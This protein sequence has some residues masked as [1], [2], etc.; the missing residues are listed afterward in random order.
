MDSP[1]TT[2][3]LR[4]LL[5]WHL[6]AGV[7]ETIGEAPVDRYAVHS[8]QMAARKQAVVAPGPAPDKRAAPAIG[9][10]AA[11]HDAVALAAGASSVAELKAAVER[12]EGCGLKETATN[13]CF[14]DGNPEARL[15]LIGEG[16]GAEEDRQGRPFV[17]PSG[18]LLDKML[19]SIGLDRSRVLISNTVFWRPPGNRTP[20][21]AEIAVCMP[22]V[23]R[24]IELVDPTVLV[25]VGGPAATSLLAQTKGVGKLRGLWFDY[26]SKGLPRPVAATA[27]F[28]PAYLLRTPARKRLAWADLLMIRA[29]LLE[30]DH[31]R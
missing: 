29:R 13:T 18:Q 17:G 11:V 31:S 30:I 27:I 23:E 7:D 25:C 6:Q 22:F 4:A 16:P 21:S 1:Q 10:T 26:A 5:A 2:T 19:A 8:A 28:H 14:Y 9:G 3:E 24:L 12:F 15:V 20:T